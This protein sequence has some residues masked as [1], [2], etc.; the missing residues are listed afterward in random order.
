MRKSYENYLDESDDDLILENKSNQN[1]RKTMDGK[2]NED[3]LKKAKLN[4]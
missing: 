2:K 4:K 1:K 3:T